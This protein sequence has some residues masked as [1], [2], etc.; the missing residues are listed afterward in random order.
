MSRTPEDL[1]SWKALIQ[2]NPRKV[3]DLYQTD[4]EL[5]AQILLTPEFY[6]LLR[7]I[8][9]PSTDLCKKAL[10]RDVNT[11]KYLHCKLTSELKQIISQHSKV[12]ENKTSSFSQE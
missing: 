8:K 10:A 5:A 1:H 3:V 2:Q 11:L 12:S 6:P 4:P 9:N 7:H